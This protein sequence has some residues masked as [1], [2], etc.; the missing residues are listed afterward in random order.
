MPEDMDPALPTGPRDESQDEGA[1]SEES[2][3]EAQVDNFLARFNV[4]QD[5]ETE[6]PSVPKQ[7][8]KP[9]CSGLE[10]A[11]EF[12]AAG[13]AVAFLAKVGDKL[14]YEHVNHAWW[15]TGR[16]EVLRIK[17]NGDV[18]MWSPGDCAHSMTNWR[19]AHG[20]GHKLYLET[21]RSKVTLTGTRSRGRPKKDRPPPP[22]VQ[23][24]PDGQ[25]VKRKRG[26]PKG[27]KNKSTLNREQSEAIRVKA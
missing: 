18:I 11:V 8:Y 26:R 9:D 4:A 5:E 15:P 1:P 22:P 6:P 17:D 3:I 14:I 12:D 16:F 7:V 13:N 19:T 24:G 21:P 25:P 2:L 23:L 20:L 10:C 27:S